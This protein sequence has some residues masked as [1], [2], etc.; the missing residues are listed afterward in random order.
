MLY[1]FCSATGCT[2]GLSP[3]DNLIQDVAG[4]LYGAAFSGGSYGGGIVFKSILIQT[5]T[6][7]VTPSLSSI[8]SSQ[9]LTVG[10]TVGGVNGDPA[11]SD[12]VT[13]ASGSYTSAATTLT[14]GGATINIPSGSLS[15]ETDTLTVSYSGDNTYQSATGAATVTVVV[16]PASRSAARRSRSRRARPPAI[17][18]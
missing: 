7:T 2:D 4:N 5:P 12:T 10:V 6:L 13:L 16:S 14:G 17:L 15:V 1:N 11:P 8:T 3:L 9:A 18:R